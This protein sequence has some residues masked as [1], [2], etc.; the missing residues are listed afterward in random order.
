[1]IDCYY[2]GAAHTT[3][4]IVVWIPTEQILFA[5]CMAKSLN[6]QNLGNTAD[7][8]LKAYPET[9]RKVIAKFPDARIVIPGH[10]QYGGIEVLKHT[11]QLA[12]QYSK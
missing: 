1:M 2:F 4:N 5:G 3:D 11:L 8:D 10:G 6:S 9:L 12:E 7:G